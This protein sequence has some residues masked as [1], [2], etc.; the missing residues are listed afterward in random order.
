[1]T[2]KVYSLFVELLTTPDAIFDDDEFKFGNGGINL[3]G[4][5]IVF[6]ESDID[7]PEISVSG[8][9]KCNGVSH[10]THIPHLSQG[11]NMTKASDISI[12]L[13]GGSSN[14]DPKLSLGGE[15]SSNIVVN[16]RLNNLFD[17]TSTENSGDIFED[18][19]CI[20]VF[21]D[22]GTPIYN[23]KLW[24]TEEQEGGGNIELGIKDS[25]EI[26]RIT[27]SP[28]PTTGSMN[29]S[30]DGVNFVSNANSNIIT[31]A[32]SLQD[33]LNS[34]ENEYRL[35]REVSVTVE[36]LND[37]IIFDIDF[38]GDLGGLGHDDKKDHPLINHISNTFVD[39][40]V[41]INVITN[42]SPLN[43]IAELIENKFIPPSGVGFYKPTE[44][45]PITFPRILPTEGFALW[46]K[47][48]IPDNIPAVQ[49]D[50]FIFRIRANS[51]D[52]YS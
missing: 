11:I 34:L 45:S 48:L 33:S 31:W 49:N 24:I 3:N 36:Q 52:P 14:L 10:V 51:I 1:M 6:L 21:N 27:I 30:Y 8:G 39:S 44:N 7:L 26:Q 16:N 35:L 50:G 29:L 20:Y 22:G 47:R 37:E 43:A 2:T 9:I 17:D 32:Q 5:A 28:I 15:P 12:V 18:Y 38:S 19:R 25:S 23:V 42:G 13:S 41:S 40:E 4:S 46:C